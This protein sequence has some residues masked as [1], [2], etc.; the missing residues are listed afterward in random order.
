MREAL[1]ITALRCRLVGD[2]AQP[3]ADPGDLHACTPTVTATSARSCRRRS[4]RHRWRCAAATRKAWPQRGTSQVVNQVLCCLGGRDLTTRFR[5]NR[6][7]V[8]MLAPI[9]SEA[10]ARALLVTL[11]DAE[12][13]F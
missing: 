12:P 9:G 7:S 13:E 4:G 8:P 2:G 11:S 5:P 3:G 1:Q 6:A 10:L